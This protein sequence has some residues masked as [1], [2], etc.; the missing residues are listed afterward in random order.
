M[1]G[2]F[3]ALGVVAPDAL[4]RVSAAMAHRGP[5]AE[6]RFANADV[7][8]L[9]RRLKIIDLS[10]AG[11]QPMPN[12]DGSVQVVFNG[13]IYNHHEL[14]RQLERA[15]HRFRSRCDTEVIAHG[16]EQWG[17]GVVEK[18]DGMFSFGLWDARRQRLLLA[19]DR[20]GKKPL[21]FSRT[22]TFRFASTISALHAAGAPRGV[23]T[24][25][26][27]FYLAYG[28][29]PPPATHFAGIERLL[30]ASLMTVEN[31]RIETRRYW[32]PHFGEFPPSDPRVA[33]VYGFRDAARAV[34]KLVTHAVERRLESDV[35]LGAF[36]SGG[37]DSTIV[38]GLMSRLMKRKVKTFSIGFAGDPRYDETGY[39][40]LASQAFDTDHVEFRLEPS[41]IELLEELVRQ[42]EAP[43]GD[44]SAI[45][46]YTVARLTRQHVT[47]AL[48]G[49][50][51]D[52]LF[53][54]YSRFL[55]A[56]LA[57]QIPLAVRP[58]VARLSA[59]LPGIAQERSLVGRA[60]RFLGAVDLT[61]ADRM[62]RWNSFFADPRDVLRADV[63]AA[64]GPA[65]EAP[66][67]WQRV[68]FNQSHGRTVLA[69]VL[70]HNFRTYLP[71]DLL[72]KADRTSMAHGLELRSPFLDTALVQYAGALPAQFLRRGTQTKRIL[73]YAFHDLLPAAIQ[74]RGKMGFGVPL[75]TWFRTNLSDYLNDHFG[76]TARMFDFVDRV[77]VAR[78]VDEHER[79]V[80][81]HSQRLWLLLTLEVWLKSTQQQAMACA[82]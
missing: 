81:D 55:A 15:G 75:A 29:V 32:E 27:P 45:P 79:S 35:P 5:D 53:C 49:D 10:P 70:E 76:P 25:A 3:G 71:Y 42:H 12:E 2:I 58:S 23:S 8:L 80:A 11:N 77:K 64:L 73:R 21:Y 61:L 68:V 60:L 46:T 30:P 31:G 22:P 50:G 44:S 33:G 17:D 39:A 82:A 54:G 24:E 18:L 38:V 56:E 52:E 14:R 59:L 37:I 62:A 20:V 41:S 48:T 16:Y 13:E 66:M 36:L 57:E 78:L 28:F 67:L 7:T 63:A 40:R 26:L 4:E 1:C 47:V 34:R 43:F 69:R 9:H 72:I 51:G 6:G 65:L 74:R 19:R